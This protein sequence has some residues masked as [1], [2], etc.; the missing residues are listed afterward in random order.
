M[1]AGQAPRVA[2]PARGASPRCQPA[3]PARS[4]A[5]GQKVENRKIVVE[6]NCCPGLS[7]VEGKFGWFGE[8]G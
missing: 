6:S 1:T 8:S 3:V 7:T 4:G 5:A 2:V